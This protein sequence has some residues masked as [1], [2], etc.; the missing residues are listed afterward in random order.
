M[1]SMKTCGVL[2]AGGESRRFG[3]DKAFADFQGSHFYQVIINELMKSVE[4]CVVVTKPALIEE[5]VLEEKNRV[6]T[7][8]VSVA[9]K[10]PLAGLLSTMNEQEADQYVV[11][12]CDMPLVKEELFSKLL[13]ESLN[14]PEA[15]A[16]IPIAEGR[17]QPLCAVYNNTCKD[18]IEMKLSQGEKR[19]MDVLKELTVRYVKMEPAELEFFTNVNTLEEYKVI[20]KEQDR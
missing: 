10:G 18:T 8:D 11:V 14:H 20:R 12:A 15:D 7:D 16:I 2:L 17:I 3:R 19:V 13:E 6:I 5:F 4:E 9:G 1:V